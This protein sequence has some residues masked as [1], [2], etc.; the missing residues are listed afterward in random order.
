VAEGASASTPTW[1]DDRLNEVTQR[2]SLLYENHLKAVL[3]RDCLGQVVAIHP[4]SGEYAVADQEEDAV[5]EL[6][7]RQ[8]DGLLFV[9]RIG[10]PTP[11]DL[12]LA[13][14]LTEHL[15]GK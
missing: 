10:P 1:Q 3:E 5:G 9:R 12:R 7:Q 13:A 14:R 2:G 15:R 6:R 11:S 8:P 4:D